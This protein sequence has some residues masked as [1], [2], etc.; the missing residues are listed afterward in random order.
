VRIDCALLCDAA[1]VREGL[2]HILGGG[3]TRVGLGQLPGHMNAALAIRVMVHPT[4]ADRPHDLEVR[5]L[6]A[7]GV[8]IGKVDVHF[9]VGKPDGEALPGGE[10]TAPFAVP[11]HL[12]QM[13]AAGGYSF[14]LLIDGVHQASVPFDVE[15]RTA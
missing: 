6:S 10:L 3:V 13:Q 12:I 14:E 5:L 2:L 1:S 4:E 15:V 11:L 8:E 9:T 7:D